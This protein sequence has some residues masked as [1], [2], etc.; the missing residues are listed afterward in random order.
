MSEASQGKLK[1]LVNFK[2]SNSSDLYIYFLIRDKITTDNIKQLKINGCFTS[3][4]HT[5]IENNK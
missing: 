5:G 1:H 3:I 4:I 2:S